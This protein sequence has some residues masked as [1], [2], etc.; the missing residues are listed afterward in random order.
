M[1]LAAAKADSP[2]AMHTGTAD[3]MSR[4]VFV[5]FT[6]CTGADTLAPAADNGLLS[7]PAGTGRKRADRDDVAVAF[8]QMRLGRRMTSGAGRLRRRRS[9][10]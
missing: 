1:A 2:G 5:A 9:P 3:M 8:S 7:L 10:W 4:I 6:S